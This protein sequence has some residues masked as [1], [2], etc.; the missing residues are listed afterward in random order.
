[1]PTLKEFI[2]KRTA[3]FVRKKL[4][5]DVDED[6]PLF[7]IYKLCEQNRTNGFKFIQ[8]MLED[9]HDV[10]TG[11]LKQ[12]FAN[13]IGTKVVTNREINPKLRGLYN[14]TLRRRKKN[15]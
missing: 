13:K 3:T 1:M 6:T 8:K 9:F 12:T 2:R 11:I 15:V 7:K 4:T 14:S 5:G 10:C